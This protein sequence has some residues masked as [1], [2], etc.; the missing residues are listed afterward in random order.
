MV[1]LPFRLKVAGKDLSAAATVAW[2]TF[3]LQG[4]L[5]FDGSLLRLEWSGTGAVDAV[6]GIEVRSETVSLPTECLGIP[7][8]RVRSIR[9][10]GGWWRP[11]LEVTANDLDALAPVPSS[12]GGRVRLWLARRDRALAAAVVA[13]I[14][15]AARTAQPLDPPAALRLPVT[16]PPEG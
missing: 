14:L 2:T 10:L 16:T 12:E 3:R 9:L 11:R 7:L 1:P 15:Q 6:T 4:L 8:H 5:A 13:A